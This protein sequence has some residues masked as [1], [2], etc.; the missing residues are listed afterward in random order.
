[1]IMNKANNNDGSF[2]S[3]LKIK[4]RLKDVSMYV[5]DIRDIFSPVSIKGS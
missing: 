3:P 1:M 4:P 2:D 5:F